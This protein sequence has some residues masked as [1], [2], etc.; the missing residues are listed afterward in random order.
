ML[1]FCHGGAF[2]PPR[3]LARLKSITQTQYFAI[4][5]IALAIKMAYWKT[6]IKYDLMGIQNTH[7]VGKHHHAPYAVF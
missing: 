6:K 7:L 1:L 2:S 4:V 3:W 5:F